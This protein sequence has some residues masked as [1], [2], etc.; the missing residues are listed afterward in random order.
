MELRGAT[1]A[2][3]GL[4]ATALA[5]TRLLLREGALP[6]VTESRA[7]PPGD[8]ALATLDALGV[9]HETGG[10]TR[11]FLEGAALIV[12]SPGVP[13]TLPVIEA[14]RAAGAQVCGEMELAA[15]FCAAPIIAVTGT[16]GKT[17]VTA[18][19]DHL[20]RHCGARTLLAGNNDL[21]LSAAVLR[22]PAPDWVVLEVSSYQLETAHTFRPR[23]AAVLNLSPDHL[24]RHGSMEN[25]A[26]A[27][28]R[29][30]ARQGPGCIAV[31]NADDPWTARLPVPEGAA[32]HWFGSGPLPGPGVWRDGA[33]LVDHAG[34]FIADAADVPLPGRHNAANALAALTLLR[35]A[36]Y[37]AEALRAGLLTFPGVEHR[38]EFVA[39]IDGVRYY[40]DSKSTNI[41]SLKVALESFPAPVVLLAGG[42][43]KGADYGALADL[44]KARVAHLVVF[45]EDA[46][47]LRAAFGG[48]VP[49]E[50]ADG[51][52][53]AA[54]LARAAARPGGVVLLSPACASFDMFENFEARGRAFKQWVREL[55]DAAEGIPG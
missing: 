40:N 29:I 19:I 36:D 45:G 15:R 28:A 30:F 2:I 27:K 1:V 53:E 20:L 17:T 55:A 4:G 7:L 26:A 33:R 41:D 35:A 47:A 21:P 6:R 31:R 44:V 9:P 24:A 14:A 34:E 11:A 42:Q 50:T 38:I 43:G 5:L 8:P 51:L 32:A 52:R 48:L 3:A 23:M 46:P 18:L 13:P 54:L 37:P 49:T 22:A 10:H 12:P 39:E 16:N 25:Y